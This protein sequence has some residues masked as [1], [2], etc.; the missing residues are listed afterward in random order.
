MFDCEQSLMWSKS[1]S[2]QTLISLK[3]V[4]IRGSGKSL[5][6]ERRFGRLQEA[7]SFSGT[8][9]KNHNLLNCYDTCHKNPRELGGRAVTRCYLKWHTCAISQGTCPIY[10]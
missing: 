4:E 3:L 2:R 5:Q 9:F 7:P 10:S 8:I 6:Q 1:C